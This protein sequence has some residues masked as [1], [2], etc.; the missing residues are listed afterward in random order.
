MKIPAAFVIVAT[1]L[2]VVVYSCSRPAVYDW[3]LPT[4]PKSMSWDQEN[5]KQNDHGCPT[6][7][8][9]APDGN[10]RLCPTS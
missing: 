3:T 7:I 9:D 1:L 10:L 4:A 6:A 8:Y 5:L 2:G